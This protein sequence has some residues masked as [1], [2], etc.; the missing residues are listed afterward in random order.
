M[1]KVDP[2]ELMEIIVRFEER[3]ISPVDLSDWAVSL[4]EKGIESESIIFLAGL[5]KAEYGDAPE[6]L[7]RA[8]S[9]LGFLW[10]SDDTIDLVY[11]KMVAND[12]ISGEIQPNLGCAL[13]DDISN[14]FIFGGP[15]EN[16]TDQMWEFHFLAHDQTG[17]EHL[18]ITAENIIPYIMEAANKLLKELSE[19]DLSL[20]P[21]V[22]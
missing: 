17:H 15:H 18:V 16:E 6:L 7:K 20:Q 12:I 19:F 21:I 1:L 14:P 2:S 5:I 13:I 11:M 9:E 3:C 22:G 10:P 4:F 8:V